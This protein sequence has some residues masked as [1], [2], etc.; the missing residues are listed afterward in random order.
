[1]CTIEVA[2]WVEVGLFWLRLQ[3]HVTS[4]ICRV[5]A[6]LVLKT[7]FG[8]NPSIEKFARA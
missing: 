6:A 8:S 7:Q 3:S 1:M 2:V 4:G 5:V